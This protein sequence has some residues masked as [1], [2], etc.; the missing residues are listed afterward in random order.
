MLEDN[1]YMM[2][3]KCFYWGLGQYLKDYVALQHR[4]LQ[5]FAAAGAAQVQE[6][7]ASR[8]LL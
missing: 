7:S 4:K 3:L 6:V 2:V 8:Q 1:K 5:H